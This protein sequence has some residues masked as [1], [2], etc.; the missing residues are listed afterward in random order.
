MSTRYPNKLPFSADVDNLYTHGSLVDEDILCAFGNKTFHYLDPFQSLSMSDQQQEED[1]NQKQDIMLNSMMNLFE[2][3]ELLNAEA[4]S[5]FE[6]F[7]FPDDIE[8]GIEDDVT[9]GEMLESLIA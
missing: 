3:E 6:D 8:S 1:R 5:F 9:F 7:Q 4:E 2:K